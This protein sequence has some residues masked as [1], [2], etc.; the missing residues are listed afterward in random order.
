MRQI[1]LLSALLLL[2]LGSCSRESSTLY[3]LELAA[4]TESEVAV[5]LLLDQDLAGQI[6]LVAIFTP[7][8]GLHLYSKDLPWLGVG[9]LGRPTRLELPEGTR[10]RPT[11]ALSESVAALPPDGTQGLAVYPP[12]PLTLRLPVVLPSGSGWYEEQVS[13]TYMACTDS[14]C[15]PPVVGKLIP[16][17]VPGQAT[18]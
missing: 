5:E 1:P 17:R 14:R 15:F 9:G 13:V 12:G 4:F 3:P 2:A 11:G 8:P 10:L 6:Y 16:V 18:P 7:G